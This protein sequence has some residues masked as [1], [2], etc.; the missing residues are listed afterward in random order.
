[1]QPFAERHGLAAAMVAPTKIIAG[2]GASLGVDILHVRQ[3]SSWPN[4]VV[5]LAS[6]SVGSSQCTMGLCMQAQR[7][8]VYWA[9][10]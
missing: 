5:K 3:L 10:T 1:M 6:D 4:I 2:L 9:S 7:A 8:G